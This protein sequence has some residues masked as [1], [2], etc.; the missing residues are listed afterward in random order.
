MYDLFQVLDL[1]PTCL[2]HF[3][4]VMHLKQVIHVTHIELTKCAAPDEGKLN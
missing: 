2:Q 1:Y 3:F 4:Q